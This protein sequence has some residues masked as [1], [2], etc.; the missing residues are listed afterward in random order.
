MTLQKTC[1][2]LLFVCAL[3]GCGGGAAAVALAGGAASTTPATDPT[4]L[5]AGVDYTRLADFSGYDNWVCDNATVLDTDTGEV[6][7]PRV[8]ITDSDGALHREVSSNSIPHHHVGDFPNVGNPNAID[9][10]AVA[11]PARERL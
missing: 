4:P 6:L 9:E 11:E 5:Q 7:A 8:V 2:G 10:V 3:A 1:L